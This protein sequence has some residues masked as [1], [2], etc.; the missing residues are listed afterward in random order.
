MKKQVT[1]MLVSAVVSLLT[2]IA[3]GVARSYGI[4]VPP[5]CCTSVQAGA[6]R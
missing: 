2:C 6:Q 1:V 5:S 3:V 4:D